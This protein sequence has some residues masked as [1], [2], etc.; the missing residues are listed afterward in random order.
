MRSPS[1]RL[2]RLATPG[3]PRP[4]ASDAEPDPC[5]HE[6]RHPELLLAG[7]SLTAGWPAVAS[8][9]GPPRFTLAQEVGL[10]FG[11]C[12]VLLPVA[13]R[14]ALARFRPAQPKAWRLAVKLACI[15]ILLFLTALGTAHFVLQKRPPPSR[16]PSQAV[17]QIELPGIWHD[18]FPSGGL[19]SFLHASDESLARLVCGNHFLTNMVPATYT[20]R[21]ANGEVAL[22]L[23]QMRTG[24][25]HAYVDPLKFEGVGLLPQCGVYTTDGARYFTR[26]ETDAVLN[27]F[28]LARGQWDAKKGSLPELLAYFPKGWPNPQIN[29][30]E[31]GP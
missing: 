14:A 19:K 29:P 13:I 22:L 30:G 24:I 18:P 10:T 25:A 4:R 8:L 31:A 23:L 28:R 26:A 5:P 3:N 17:Y 20:I 21:R 1:P 12:L 2:P 7:F 9:P 16:D 6:A 11:V 15:P 27:A